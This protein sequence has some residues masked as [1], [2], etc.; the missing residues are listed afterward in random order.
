MAFYERIRD[1]VSGPI[2]DEMIQQR[3]LAGWQMESIEWRREM[4]EGAM[5]A[6]G[7]VS[8]EIPYGLRIS[9]D[10]SRLED[11][12][13]EHQ[14][15]LRMMELLVQDYSYSAIVSDL[16]D[17]G[18]RM[19]DGNPWNRVAVFNMVPRLIDVGPHFFSTLDWE[20]RRKK[21]ARGKAEQ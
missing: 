11:D 7:A 2:S 8:E 6:R 1:V 16:N 4:P 12:P 3:R 20:E 14:A 15:L 19:R 10:G 9:D 13:G 5:A 21:F 18:F 17:R